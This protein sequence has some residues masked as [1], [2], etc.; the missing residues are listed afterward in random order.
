[1]PSASAR[2]V[3]KCLLS[4]KVLVVLKSA[5][6]ASAYFLIL[7]VQ[8]CL[9]FYKHGATAKQSALKIARDK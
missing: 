6:G 4:A 1:M 5:S 8:P 2:I 3:L 7:L 9:I